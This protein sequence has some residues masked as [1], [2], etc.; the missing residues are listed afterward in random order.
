M[1]TEAEQQEA[2]A[3]DSLPDD[4]DWQ[5]LHSLADRGFRATAGQLLSQGA[6]AGDLAE[7]ATEAAELLGSVQARI[8]P[9]D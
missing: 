5:G 3:T 9:K 8:N 4:L 7:F 6:P 2:P 1:N